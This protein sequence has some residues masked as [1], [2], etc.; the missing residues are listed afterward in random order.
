MSVTRVRELI[1]AGRVSVQ[2]ADIAADLKRVA[3]MFDCVQAAHRPG[4]FLQAQNLGYPSHVLARAITEHMASAQIAIENDDWSA[5][6]KAT[7]FLHDE[8]VVEMLD[9]YI[10]VAKGVPQPIEQGFAYLAWRK[11][12]RDELA[13]GA[14]SGSLPDILSGLGSRG[15]VSTGRNWGVLGAWL[16]HDPGSAEEEIAR[17]A[18]GDWN[19]VSGSPAYIADRARQIIIDVESMLISTCNLI[20]SPWHADDELTFRQLRLGAPGL[21]R[22]VALPQPTMTR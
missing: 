5:L 16:V 8:A 21:G 6:R 4:W 15:S 7:D 13:V 20:L 14:S 10:G 19:V 11:D 2:H 9:N 18:R 22:E 17:M 1:L 3:Y 12:G